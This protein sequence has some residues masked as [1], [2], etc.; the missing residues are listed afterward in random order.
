MLAYSAAAIVSTTTVFI[1]VLTAPSDS[2]PALDN[3]LQFYALTE[4]NRQVILGP[5]IPFL[6]VPVVMFVDMMIRLAGLVNAG[7]KSLQMKA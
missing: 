2:D 7:M 1:M 4:E 5:L 6:I 3:T